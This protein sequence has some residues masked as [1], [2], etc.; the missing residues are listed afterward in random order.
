MADQTAKKQVAVRLPIREKAELEREAA[1][2][3]VSRSEYIRSTLRERHR[4]AELEARLE[5]RE[6]RIDEL[7]AQLSR[8]AEIEEK[9]E[10]L[11][12]KIQDEQTYQERRQRALD[13][14]S[15]LE[16]L[17]WR[18]TGVPVERIDEVGSGSNDDEA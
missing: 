7:E 8:R 17:K 15:A 16:R 4:A 6:Q 12:A 1:E 18:L 5:T 14:A 2:R 13:S 10:Q 9:I 11:P 3:G